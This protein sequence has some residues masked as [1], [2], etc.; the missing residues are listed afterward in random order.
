R[1]VHGIICR[2]HEHETIEELALASSVPVVNALSERSH[3][4]QALADVMV[5]E[6]RFGDLRGLRLVFVGPAN[7]VCHSLLEAGPQAGFDVIVACP[8]GLGPDPAVLD[9]ARADA[10]AARTT[11]AVEHDPAAAVAGARAV[12][13][14]TW[15][16][17]GQEAEAEALRR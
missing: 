17:M 2:W 3:P 11:I 4:C 16:S 8:P 14:D 6:E 5:L 7:N 10:E 15:V 13:T 9:R 1:F 12:Y